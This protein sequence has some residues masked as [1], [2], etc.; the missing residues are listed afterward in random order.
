MRRERGRLVGGADLREPEVD[1]LGHDVAAHVAR[2]ED[3]GGLEVAVE[4]PQVVRLREGRGDGE[5]ESEGV[6]DREDVDPGE[7]RAEIAPAEELHHEVRNARLDPNVEH[8]HGVRVVETGRDA[9]LAKEAALHLLVVRE[10]LVED[11]D[12]DLLV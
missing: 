8:I 3:V 5:N 9:P 2:E 1:Q 12:R 7:K 6:L 10:V 4:N 11:P